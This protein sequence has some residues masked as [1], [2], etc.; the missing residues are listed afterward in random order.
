MGPRHI[1]S[2]FL[3]LKLKG[4][5]GTSTFI[6]DAQQ[7]S[8]QSRGE[9]RENISCVSGG[10][11]EKFQLTVYKSS[12]SVSY[13]FCPQFFLGSENST[14]FGGTFLF[15][16]AMWG[17]RTPPTN[18]WHSNVWRITR[19][20]FIPKIV[21]RHWS[22]LLAATSSGSLWGCKRFPWVGQV[23]RKGGNDLKKPKYNGL[24]EY[25][26]CL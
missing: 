24:E 25:E 17:E 16:P 23:Q 19:G 14:A 6:L 15:S 12:T 9:T 2:L 7:I 18:N 26:T 22:S 8:I 10:Q 11:G 1:Y 3:W 13:W 5:I 4:I 20:K 21:V